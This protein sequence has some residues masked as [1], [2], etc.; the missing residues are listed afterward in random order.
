VLLLLIP[1][2]EHGLRM[3]SIT[4]GL[5]VVALVLFMHAV[6]IRFW[7]YAFYRAA[8]AAGVLRRARRGHRRRARRAHPAKRLLNQPERA[9]PLICLG[10]LMPERVA[11]GA[12]VPGI[13]PT[14]PD[15]TGRRIR[16]L[17]ITISQLL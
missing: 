12:S 13:C 1:A 17:P 9:P 8:I 15:A 16:A 2:N 5:E 4:H 11:V 6:A 10:M 7:N 3:L 14:V